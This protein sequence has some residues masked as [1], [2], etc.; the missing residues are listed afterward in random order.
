LLA[1]GQDITQEMK[2]QKETLE[3]KTYEAIG[4]FSED[5]AR[6]LEEI[7][8]ALSENISLL[9]TKMNTE[10]EQIR[11]LEKIKNAAKRTEELTS[12]IAPH[13][14]KKKP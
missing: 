8:A 12:R 13:K 11:Y 14:K 4:N 1:V 3:A 5:F 6:E 9:E 10:D 2:R 7:T